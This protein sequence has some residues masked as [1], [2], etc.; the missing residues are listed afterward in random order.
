MLIW[1]AYGE[2]DLTAFRDC[3]HG[4]ERI[5]NTIRHEVQLAHTVGT[6]ICLVY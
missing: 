4:E 2:E 1:L 6:Q 3:S 5:L